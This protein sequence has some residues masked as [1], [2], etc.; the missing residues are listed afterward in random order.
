[1]FNLTLR[2]SRHDFSRLQDHHNIHHHIQSHALHRLIA[3]FSL[4]ECDFAPRRADRRPPQGV[5]PLLVDR[6][7]PNMSLEQLDSYDC[8]SRDQSIVSSARA[9]DPRPREE[10]VV[11]RSPPRKDN[12]EEPLNPPN[13]AARAT[14]HPPG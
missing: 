14:A 8:A 4:D 7:S 3:S 6:Y 13:A 9:D 11:E 1:M 12:D 2:G 5:A 10:D